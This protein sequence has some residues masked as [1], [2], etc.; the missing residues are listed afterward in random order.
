MVHRERGCYR[1]VGNPEEVK[2][3]GKSNMDNRLTQ[4]SEDASHKLFVG[5]G[6][7]AWARVCAPPACTA[8]TLSPD[9]WPHANRTLT[10]APACAR[11][12]H[13]SWPTA[14]SEAAARSAASLRIERGRARRRGGRA[15]SSRS[16]ASASRACRSATAVQRTRH[17][18]A[19]TRAATRSVARRSSRGLAR[20]AS[21]VR[22]ASPAC[23]PA[24]CTR[25]L[26]PRARC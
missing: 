21:T 4:T 7:G 14:R 2:R 10:A 16:P 23:P 17:A 20:S 3:V 22:I 13:R 15:S 9:W 8:T 18:S 24:P 6:T 5:L 25:S 1:G 26:A 19:A 11:V 12:H